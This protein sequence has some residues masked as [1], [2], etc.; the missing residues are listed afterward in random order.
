MSQAL[1]ENDDIPCHLGYRL[2]T[3]SLAQHR[4]SGA[5]SQSEGRRNHL[6]FNKGF[7]STLHSLIFLTHR[8]LGRRD[9]LGEIR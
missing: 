2:K 9:D 1:S 4:P 3:D 7:E 5:E 6:Y 8:H